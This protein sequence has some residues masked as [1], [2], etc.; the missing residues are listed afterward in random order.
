MKIALYLGYQPPEIGGGYTFIDEVIT[1]LLHRP[2]AGHQLCIAACGGLWSERT[3]QAGVEFIHLPSRPPQPVETFWRRLILSR[4][5]R[6]FLSQPAPGHH[7]FLA[8]AGVQ[9]LLNFSPYETASPEIPYINIVW[10]LQHRL[11]PMFP[12]VSGEGVWEARERKVRPLLQRA[13]FVIVGTQAG[14][15]EVENFYGVSSQR[16][17][18]LPHPTPSF[19]LNA[20]TGGGLDPC[21]RFGL[22][23]DYFFYPAQ[24]WAHKNHATLLLA[25]RHLRERHGVTVT[26]AFSGSDQGN[27][28]YVERLAEDYGLRKQVHFLGFV[29]REELIGLYRHALALAYVSHFGPEN[30]PPLEACALGCPVIAARVDGAEE[31][32][33]DAALLVDAT[34][35]EELAAAMLR[36]IQEPALRVELRERGL[37]RSKRFTSGDFAAGLG[38]IFDEAE[39]LRRC[40]A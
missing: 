30:L 31:Q 11:Q 27:Q 1:A 32:L 13:S 22:P 4:C 8:A 7:R 33:G 37:R 10:D 21:A 39:K 19:A 23:R 38:A 40:W 24:F 34:A 5:E 18:R 29:Q 15:E 28:S 36:I 35:P 14:Q 3:Q 17:R 2:P 16:I 9:W 25:A 20:P 12:E 26:L 6:L